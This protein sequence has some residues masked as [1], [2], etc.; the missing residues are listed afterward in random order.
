MLNKSKTIFCDLDGTLVKHCGNPCL[1]ANPKY[2]LE[3]LSGVHERL[4]C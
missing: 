3:V 1:I 2:E 4:G